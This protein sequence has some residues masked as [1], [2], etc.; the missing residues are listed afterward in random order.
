MPAMVLSVSKTMRVKA[1]TL[2]ARVYPGDV[3]EGAEA[4][5]QLDQGTTIDVIYESNE[6]SAFMYNGRL[7]WVKSEYLE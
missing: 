3:V 1:D 5:T 2:N 7:L 4:V 6:W